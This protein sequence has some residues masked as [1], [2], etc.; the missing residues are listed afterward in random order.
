MLRD[1][2]EVKKKNIFT[3][4]VFLNQSHPASYDPHIL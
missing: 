4:F 1:F 2:L 3:I